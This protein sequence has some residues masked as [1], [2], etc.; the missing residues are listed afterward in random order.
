MLIPES[1][2]EKNPIPGSLKAFYEYHSTLMEPWDGP[3]S[4]VFSDGRYIGG[5]LDRSGLRPSRYII[6][7][8]DL[9]VMGSE[10]GVQVFPAS[11]IKEKGRLRPGQGGKSGINSQKSLCQL[12]ER[13]QIRIRRH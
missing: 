13:K 2:N 8:N 10:V 6:T 5:T 1:F 9:I 4:M 12:A 7:K 11:E 3:A